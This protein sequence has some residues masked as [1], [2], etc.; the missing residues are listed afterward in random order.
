MRSLY[1]GSR[2]PLWPVINVGVT[3]TMESLPRKDA[4]M[5]CRHGVEPGQARDYVL[6]VAETGE[7]SYH[8]QPWTL[9]V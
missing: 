2:E 6:K 7:G 5:E 1:H 4:G 9:H 3:R 8:H